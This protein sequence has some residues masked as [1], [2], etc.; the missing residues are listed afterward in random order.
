MPVGQYAPGTVLPVGA[1]WTGGGNGGVTVAVYAGMDSSSPILTAGTA[2]TSGASAATF[3]LA[4]ANI[5][6]AAWPQTDIGIGFAAIGA[7]N[8]FATAPSMCG[9]V[10]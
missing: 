2:Y 5:L 1:T 7:N 4:S 9:S 8:T 3:E 10:H 6:V